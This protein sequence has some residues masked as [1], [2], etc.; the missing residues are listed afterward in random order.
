MVGESGTERRLE[1][2]QALRAN[3]SSA[4]PVLMN[5]VVEAIHPGLAEVSPGL[6]LARPRSRQAPVSP[7]PGLAK[8]RSRLDMGTANACAR[9]VGKRKAIAAFER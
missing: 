7:S 8:P 2:F 5:T 3:K 6:G 1:P 9:R 4:P